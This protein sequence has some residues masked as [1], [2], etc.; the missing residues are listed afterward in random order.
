M[1]DLKVPYN[2]TNVTVNPD[3]LYKLPNYFGKKEKL[4]WVA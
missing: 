1:I 3:N 4:L 2:K